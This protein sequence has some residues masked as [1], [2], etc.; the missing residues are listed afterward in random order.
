[1]QAQILDLLAKIRTEL[2]CYGQIIGPPL[3]RQK[4]LELAEAWA[5]LALVGAS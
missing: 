2:F 3:E 5:L 4:T 1:M